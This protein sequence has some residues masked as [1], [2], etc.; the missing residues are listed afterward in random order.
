MKRTPSLLLSLQRG[1]DKRTPPFADGE[2][3]AQVLKGMSRWRA[4]EQKQFRALTASPSS[5]DRPEGGPKS[6]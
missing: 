4:L 3:G 1:S 2:A 6:C 5:N